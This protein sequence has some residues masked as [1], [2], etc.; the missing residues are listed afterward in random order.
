MN[1]LMTNLS[2]SCLYENHFR[3]V[4]A[5]FSKKLNQ[6]R[7]TKIPM[8]FKFHSRNNDD[9]PSDFASNKGEFQCNNYYVAFE[10]GHIVTRDATRP[11][12]RKSFTIEL[13]A[14]LDKGAHDEIYSTINWYVEI[15]FV[16]SYSEPNEKSF[17][18]HKLVTFPAILL[19][20]PTVLTIIKKWMN[21][22]PLPC[23][24]ISSMIE[25]NARDDFEFYEHHRRELFIY[26]KH[27]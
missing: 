6:G 12:F 4:M 10:S 15:T 18:A 2:F 1:K 21:N 11:T 19:L 26:P 23:E 22:Q 5:E 27:S 9:T 8:K 24:L 16:V 14:K 20:E 7:T 13:V 25:N 17:F 3:N